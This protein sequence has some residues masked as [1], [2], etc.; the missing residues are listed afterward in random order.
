MLWWF[1]PPIAKILCPYH[2]VKLPCFSHMVSQS[3]ALV[4]CV[5]WC[6]VWLVIPRMVMKTLSAL[7][8]ASFRSWVFF[9][10]Q[11]LL[12][13]PS[14]TS[15]GDL[16]IGNECGDW[17]RFSPLLS[18]RGM[19]GCNGAAILTIRPHFSVHKAPLLAMMVKRERNQGLHTLF[20]CHQH[21]KKNQGR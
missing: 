20:Y 18:E 11:S 7:I 10:R 12:P 15:T 8:L 17:H 5:K 13:F 9:L 1:V 21:C 14:V 6:F 2:V 19:E 4:F 3:S 16:H